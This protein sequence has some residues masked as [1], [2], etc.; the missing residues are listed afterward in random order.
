MGYKQGENRQQISLL[1]EALDDYVGEN[2]V[3]RFIN[4]FVDTLDL[5]ALGFTR[6][7]TADTGAPAYSPGSLLKLYVYGYLHQ[8]R[9]S[10]QL[11]RQTR[12]NIES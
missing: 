2:S 5:A 10:R 11:E 6:T 8:H 7:V 12:V 1:P 9:S 3:V 4:E